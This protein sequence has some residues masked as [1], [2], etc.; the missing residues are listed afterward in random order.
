MKKKMRAV[1]LKG[2]NDYE[3]GEVDKPVCD[4]EGLLIEVKA[5]G[6]C[7]SDLRTLSSG[8]RNVKYPWIIGHEVCGVVVE[9]GCNYRG[10]FA[11]GDVL[12]VAPPVYCGECEYC[13]KGRLELCMNMREL[14]QQ[15]KGGFAEYMAIPPEALRNGI[16]VKVTDGL[17][18]SAIALAEPPSSCV[19][20][21]EKLST[22]IHDDVLIIG[23]GPIGCLHV[24]LAMARGAKRIFI[25][26]VSE[27]RLEMC[28]AL[29]DVTTIN[30]VQT[31]LVQRVKELTEGYGPDVVITANPIGATQVQAVEAVKKGGRIAFFGGLPDG[32]STPM[33]DTN[34][35]HYK[36]ITIIG[37]TN[38]APHHYLTALALIRSGR[39]P[40]GKLVTHI[41]PLE[42]FA[43]GVALA[44][45][46]K[47][48][49]VVFTP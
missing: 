20:A 1:I 10:K 21:H 35:V 6:L 11:M 15:W 41:L 34:M 12:A 43:E 45:E 5:C 33:I 32:N 30:S 8:H 47:A 37:T 13:K 39:I 23:A 3:Y 16:I 26:D 27:S 29:G 46:G 48:L 14:A 22:G 24:C 42:R 18:Y 9:T 4:K 7:G 31:D 49:K 40:A 2:F 17:D 36:G 25:A 28:K 38:F 44:R 19:S